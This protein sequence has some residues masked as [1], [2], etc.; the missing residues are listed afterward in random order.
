MTQ[1][2]SEG[3]L[4]LAG[5]SK[6]LPV[7]AEFNGAELRVFDE[8][9]NCVGS[10]VHEE[11]NAKSKL[12]SLPRELLLPTRELLQIS[13][14]D[15]VNQW[16]DAHSKAK[17]HALESSKSTILFSIF[18]VPISLVGI[19]KYLL[20][21]LA[22]QFAAIVPDGV[23]SV[24][25]QQTLTTLDYTALEPS[26]LS[27]ETQTQI[28][29]YFA[30]TVLA[31]NGS[32]AQFNLHFRQSDMMGANAFALPDGTIVITDELVQL[33]EEDEDL[34][35]AIFLHELGHVAHD[36]S[37]RLIAETLVTSLAI[38]Y[39]IGDL[40]AMVELVAGFSS[41]VIQNQYSQELE[42]EADNF[43]IDMMIAN[44][45]DPIHFANAMEK[46]KAHYMGD[47]EEPDAVSFMSS[48]PITQQRID[49]ARAQ[50]EQL[51]SHH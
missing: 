30:Q 21:Y 45:K 51:K 26:D 50:S 4:Y 19:F 17:T 7:R 20:P 41:T 34:L 22:I 1:F 27:L 36:H 10:F 31:I 14:S 9:Q 24:A 11:I 48:H 37:M 49:N 42:W 23:K 46:F 39:L 29:A 16:L 47:A 13:S 35:K 40:G 15:A 43:A 18:L 25:S 2:T 28:D 38:D 33:L 32:L 5:S 3:T 44:G 8:Q 12:G 6:A